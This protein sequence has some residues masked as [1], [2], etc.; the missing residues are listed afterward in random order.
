[1][2]L[3]WSTL[4]VS[5]C[6]SSPSPTPTPG[7]RDLVRRLRRAGVVE[8]A[9]ERG[10]GLVVDAMLD[11]DL[12]VIVA[13]NRLKHCAAGTARPATRTTGSTPTSWPTR[14]APTGFGCGR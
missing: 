8:V 11:A 7:L 6:N 5:S 10:D 14:C 4:A 12:V 3:P 2:P 13:P 9:I 1:M